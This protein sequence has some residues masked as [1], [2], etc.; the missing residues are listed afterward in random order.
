METSPAGAETELVLRNP[1]GQDC[2]LRLEEGQSLTIGRDLS[3]D[4]PV[5]DAGVSRHHALIT[6]E[7]SDLWIED[8]HSQNGT[9][10]NL[11]PVR[12]APLHAGD[13]ITFGRVSFVLST[14]IVRESAATNLH[15]LR[16][17]RL[18]QLVKAGRRLA[19]ARG[20]EAVLERLLEA[21]VDT[22]AAERGA[23]LL[24]DEE[25]RG[26]QPVASRPP[27]R[28]K[29]ALRDL[30]QAVAES[31]LREGKAHVLAAGPESLLLAPVFAGASNVGILYLARQAGE[32]AFAPADAEFIEALT[33]TA[34]PVVEASGRMAEMAAWGRQLAEITEKDRPATDS[35][36]EKSE[37]DRRGEEAAGAQEL[38][39][40]VRGFAVNRAK[41]LA[42]ED[43]PQRPAFA[44]RTLE[45]VA[46]LLA[47]VGRTLGRRSARAEEVQIGHACGEAEAGGTPFVIEEGGDLCALCDPDDLIL[48]LRLAREQLTGA[49]R[50]RSGVRVAARNEA[51]WLALGLRAGERD[52]A[53]GAGFEKSSLAVLSRLCADRL[54]GALRV[55]GTG[56]RLEIRV[57]CASVLLDTVQ[58]R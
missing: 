27:E 7:A 18:I 13:V 58:F 17:E 35:R 46:L 30:S 45:G 8:L 51:G 32:E 38:V 19:S 23:V 44:A 10:V 5:L 20:R 34:G 53:E 48:A 28:M 37:R 3:S 24:W 21:A 52:D 42:T 39:A 4:L 55:S 26:L 14:R 50:E 47:G 12:R 56:S 25:R 36:G 41:A 43:A 54:G 57:P 6:R 2:V 16:P 11:E 9:L 40:A 33:W 31:T 29:T 15:R 1:N 49:G 22:L